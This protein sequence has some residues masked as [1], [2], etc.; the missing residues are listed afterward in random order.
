M[1]FSFFLYKSKFARGPL[2]N[3]CRLFFY[4]N[5]RDIHNWK[6]TPSIIDTG[7]CLC[8]FFLENS[9][10]CW[11][12]ESPCKLY[13][14][15][16]SNKCHIHIRH[17]RFWLDLLTVC[18]VIR[19]QLC[20]FLCVIGSLPKSPLINKG[21]LKWIFDFAILHIYSKSLLLLHAASYSF[22]KT[23][24]PQKSTFGGNFFIQDKVFLLSRGFRPTLFNLRGNDCS[25]PRVNLQ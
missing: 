15:V 9:L 6:L 19:I 2:H 7:S 25:L 4:L 23:C 11:Y 20:K 18:H 16:L 10:L 24:I 14:L 5:L 1:D 22:P 12:R 21:R 17:S 8:Y 13:C 3:Y